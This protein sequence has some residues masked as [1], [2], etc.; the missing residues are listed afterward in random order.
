M[1]LAA[2]NVKIFLLAV[3][4]L[5]VM[6]VSGVCAKEYRVGYLEGGSYWTFTDTLEAIMQELAKTDQWKDL[7]W[8]GSVIIPEDLRFSPGWEPEKAPLLEQRARELMQR[9]DIDLIITAGTGATTEILKANNGK[10][11]IVA[12][13]V[14]DAVKSKFVLN[15]DDSGVDN[16]TVRIVPGRYERMFEIFHD[17]VGFQKLGLVYPD[18]DGGRK[19]SSVEDAITV[20]KRKG[21]EIESYTDISSAE[22][23]EECM[24][25][26]KYLVT[27]KKIDAF[28]IPALN[29]FDWVQSDVKPIFDFLMA[30]K[31]P[32]FSREGTKSVKAGA[33]MGFSTYDF[34]GRGKFLAERIIKILLGTSPRKLGMIDNATPKISLNIYVAEQI[35]FD[36]SFDILGASDEIFQEIT[37]PEDRLVK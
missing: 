19:F 15:Q 24:A 1:S 2:K 3:V 20:A 13:A 12:M 10:T 21:F 37:P 6:T 28:F 8:N 36:P 18:T 22:T 11:P 31:I 23:M 7:G 14:A 29:G 27:Q 9:N 33:L 5:T 32:T 17:V 35:G 34:S 25:G 4:G 26:V 16:F 30:N